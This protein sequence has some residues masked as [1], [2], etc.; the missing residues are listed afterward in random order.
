MKKTIIAVI[1][2]ACF[3]NVP[4]PTKAQI[5]IRK[6]ATPIQIQKDDLPRVRGE[7]TPIVEEI[8]VN[9][10]IKLE[11]FENDP[12]NAYIYTLENGLRVYMTVYKNVPRIQAYVAV[13]AGSKND[14]A[15]TTGLAHYFEHMMFK[16][17]QNFGT[18]DYKAESVYIN[19]IDSLFE[20]YRMMTDEKERR[21]IYKTIDSLSVLA[22]EFALANEYDKLMSIIGSNGTN[23]YTSLEQTV[24]VENIPSN[25]L[26]NWAKIQAD[27]FANPVLRLFH[28]E[29][30]TIYEEKN[31][32]MTSDNMKLYFA[33]LEG[34]F[35]NHPYGT[36]TVIGTQD[37]LKNPSMKNIREFHADYYVPNNMAICLSGD[38]EPEKAI[39]IID[40]YFGHLPS[41]EVPPFRYEPAESF[42]EPVVKEVYGQDA[43]SFFI[44]FRFEGANSRDSY[45]LAL[46]DMLL[47]N[48]AAGLFDINLLQQQ[49]LLEAYSY[50]LLMEDYSALVLAGKPKGGQT[51]DEAKDLILSQ[52]NLIREGQFEDWLL[53][54][55]IN[56]LKLREIKSYESN[57]SRASAFVEAFILGIPWDEY[58]NKIS[59]LETITKDDIIEFARKNFGKNYV[60][61][62]KRT[63]KDETIKKLPKNKVTPL[64]INRDAESDFLVQVRNNKPTDLKP[65]FLNFEED[66]TFAQLGQIPVQYIQNIE[67]ETFRLYYIFDMGTQHIKKLEPA[68]EYLEFIGT[69]Q[70][71]PEEIQKEFYKIGCRYNVYASGDQIYVSLSGLSD[72]LVEGL[73]LFE[74]LLSD[75]VPDQD[76]WDKYV[77][78]TI[79]KRLD[80]KKNIQYIFSYLITYGMF[81]KINPVTY[82]LTEKELRAIN[83]SEMTEL[84]KSLRTYHHKILF[85]GSDKLNVILSHLDKFH[86]VPEQL[87]VYPPKKEFEQLPTDKNMVYFVN[88]DTPHT[89]VLMVSRGRKGY[90]KEQAAINNLFNEYFGMNM[91]S[92][93]FQEMREARGLAYAAISFYQEPSE[94]D[95]YY[96]S[97]SYIATQYDKVEEAINGFYSLLNDMPMSEKAFE[98]AK[99]AFILKLRTER[100]TRADIFFAY[101]RALKLGLKEDIR[102]L[103]FVMAE[104][105]TLEDLRRY[106]QEY[107]K[108]KKHT[109][110]VLGNENDLKTKTLKKFGKVKKLKM[111]E[112]F[113][114]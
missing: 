71:S 16:G 43:E 100:I 99:D 19:K 106:Q 110:L 24:Y 50:N 53:K 114:F 88:F 62:Y 92:I 21:A 28:T 63:G 20:V 76:A 36:Q 47:M 14:P 78:N 73:R 91:N 40:K 45:M 108:N 10:E 30:E 23:A 94:V 98:I 32:T 27:R 41:R 111:E 7:M 56:D 90:E 85:Y 81:G 107:L 72:N 104:N 25:Q 109:T 54:A 5:D 15:E 70:Y 77:N 103:M 80:A 9:R 87:T 58:V 93:V 49:Q 26:E 4:V 46:I 2:S 34:L 11:R 82:T 64:K 66:I 55:I 38:F 18:A 29:L 61:V 89:Q 105:L 37:H 60:I 33:L 74:H 57:E 6:A 44:G 96:T 86:K 102:R 51:L 3:L 75:C 112:I 17:T 95:K 1:I 59:V 48:S 68:I 39:R 8:Y 22:S 84:I 13:K 31:M 97:I 35:P 42:K 101:H 113:G 67:N 79:Q 12:L 52:L 65:V 69:T 83:P